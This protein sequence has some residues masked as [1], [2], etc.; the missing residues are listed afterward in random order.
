MIKMKTWHH[1]ES[2]FETKDAHP[3]CFSDLSIFLIIHTAKTDRNQYQA[4]SSL[5]PIP[6]SAKKQ[7]VHHTNIGLEKIKVC[8]RKLA[9]TAK[10]VLHM[11]KPRISVLLP[12]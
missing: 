8:I 9:P 4:I 12:R 3:I 10:K 5:Q 11:S 2:R 7:L 1:L 6:T